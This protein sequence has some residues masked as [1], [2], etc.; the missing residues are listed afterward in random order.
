MKYPKRRQLKWAS[1]QNAGNVEVL[2]MRQEIVP[3]ICFRQ[4]AVIVGVQN[5]IPGIVP[6]ALVFQNVVTAVVW[7][8]PQQVVPTICFRR[9]VI[10]AGAKNIIPGTVPM[11]LPLQNVVTAVAGI[12]QPGIVLID[13]LTKIIR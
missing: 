1:L 13:L 7:I 4:S 12:I 11:A 8:M 10:I 6:M 9:S 3:T 5:I 2:I